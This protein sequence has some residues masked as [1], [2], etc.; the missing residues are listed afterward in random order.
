MTDSRNI[1]DLERNKFYQQGVSNSE[2]ALNIAT[3]HLIPIAKG[4][5]S[6]YSHVNKFGRSVDVTTAIIDVAAMPAPVVYTWLE[7]PVQ[8]EAISSDAGDV[9][10]TGAGARTIRVSGKDANFNDVSAD[11]DMAGLSASTATTQTFLRVE[12]AYVLT[13]GR[14][15]KT[16]AGSHIGT[17]TIRTKTAGATHIYI[18][19]TPAAFGQSLVARYTIPAGYTGYLIEAFFS[20]D[21]LKTADFTIFRRTNADAVTAPYGTMRAI[22]TFN[23]I[24][25]PFPRSWDV[26]IKLEEKTDI[27]VSCI[28]AA[29]STDVSASFDLLLIKDT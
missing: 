12:R 2:F 8:I 3:K 17:I 5:L 21:S 10:V 7:A 20:V 16:T 25:T 11:I 28:A 18:P 23:G 6:S 9:A 27:W 26:P 4:G 22:E 29:G 15:A 13:A 19:V 24:D 14:Y 1:G